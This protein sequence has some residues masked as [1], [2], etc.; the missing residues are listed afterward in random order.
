[1]LQQMPRL[2]QLGCG[3]V[4]QIPEWTAQWSGA[5]CFPLQSHSTCVYGYE[6]IHTC[7]NDHECLWIFRAHHL[8]E[9]N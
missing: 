3:G 5:T 2:M 7:V 8:D 9:L 1:M 6:G 4:A